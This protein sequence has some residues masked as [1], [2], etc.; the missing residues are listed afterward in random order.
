[1]SSA[2]RK[3]QQKMPYPRK[4]S[5]FQGNS[6]AKGARFGG[7]RSK[8]LIIIAIPLV[9]EVLFA[10]LVIAMGDVARRQQAAEVEAKAI[11]GSAYRLLSLLLDTETAIRGYVITSQPQFTEPYDSAI[12]EVPLEIDRLTY[13]TT[14]LSEDVSRLEQLAMSI[15]RYQKLQRDRVAGGRQIEAVTDVTRGVGKGKMDEFRV[16]IDQFLEHHHTAE[17]RRSESNAAAHQR[18]RNLVLGGLA[19]NFIAA[20]AAAVFFTTSITRRIDVLVDNTRRIEQRQPLSPLLGGKD[21]IAH[22]DARLHAMESTLT[23]NRHDLESLNSELEAFSYS[24]SHDLRAPLRAV[25]GYAR[26]LGEDYSEAL[27]AEGKRY[28]ATIRGE[29]ERMGRLIDDLLTFSRLGRNA[30][31]LATIDISGLVRDALAQISAADDP[32]VRIELDSPPPALADRAML[33]QVFVNLL[34]NAIKFSS[35]KAEALVEIG[36]SRGATENT[37]WVRDHGAGFDMRFAEKL[38][39]V[40]QRLHA[41]TEF[42]GTGVGLA[43]AQRVISRHGG[44]IWAESEEGSGASFFFTLPTPQET[45]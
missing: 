24:V 12:R 32:R 14:E 11:E 26:M 31:Q 39:G 44:R 16:A 9:F 45:Y 18:L 37:Y 40:F 35:K 3:S 34:S 5:Q 20:V 42:E 41:A 1:M 28:V 2:P 43:I 4:D 23:T 38:F 22:L 8:G 19:L 33:R 7:L 15:L 29:A 27:D 30:L 13:L 21:E 10:V 25:N 36:G 6:T 17:E